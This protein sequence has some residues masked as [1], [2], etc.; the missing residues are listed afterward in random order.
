MRAT[1]NIPDELMAKVQ[2]LAGEGSKTKAIVAAME[3]FVRLKGREELR[4]LR[5]KVEID[6][7]WQSEEAAEI[8]MQRERERIHEGD[9]AR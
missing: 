6:Y 3:S 9:G 5:G 7:D 2:R 1:L 8:E 4:A